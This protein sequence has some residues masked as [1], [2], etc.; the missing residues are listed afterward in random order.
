MNIKDFKRQHPDYADVPDQQLADALYRKHYAQTGM[1]RA[2]FYEKAQVEISE[3][4]SAPEQGSDLASVGRQV[5]PGVWRGLGDFKDMVAGAPLAA[6]DWVVND[7]VMP[8]F[9]GFQK[10]TP[11]NTVDVRVGFQSMMAPLERSAIGQAVNNA[12]QAMGRYLGSSPEPQDGAERAAARAGEIIGSTVPLVAVPYGVAATKPIQYASAPVS[13]RTAIG[14]VGENIVKG[15]MN[16]PGRTAAIEAGYGTLAG[17]GGGI[18][19]EAG[20]PTGEMI[21]SLALPVSAALATTFSPTFM[22]GRMLKTLAPSVSET[23]A[24]S[25]AREMVGQT[26]GEELPRYQGAVNRSREIEQAINQTAA[27]AGVAD[28]MNL[29]LAERTGSPAL[30]AAQRDLEGRMSGPAL[31]QAAKRRQGQDAA[32]DT[33]AQVNAPGSMMGPEDVARAAKA[34]SDAINDQL[35]RKLV[36][37]SIER[38]VLAQ[39]V[40]STDLVEAGA[41]IR[42]ALNDARKEVRGAFDQRAAA[43]GINT[44]DVTLDFRNFQQHVGDA[45]SPQTFDNPQYRPKVLDDIVRFG[46]D[47]GAQPVTFQEVKN[48]RE[49]IVDDL[50]VSQRSSNPTDRMRESSLS[51]LLRDFDGFITNTELR[52]AD[53]QLAERWT[54]FRRDYKN[55]YIDKFRQPDMRSFGARDTEGFRKMADEAVATDLFKPGNVSALRAYKDAVQAMDP[56]SPEF[57][58]GIEAIESVA[59]DSLRNAAVR[60]G[61]IDPQRYAA[62]VRQHQSM[63][64]E[65]PYLKGSVGE[66][67]AANQRLLSRQKTLQD[68]A[69]V[70]ERSVLEKKLQGIETG[71]RSP[72]ALIDEAIRNPGVASRLMSRLRNDDPAV[73]GLRAAVW[74]RIPFDDPAKTV[75]FLDANQKA[76]GAIFDPA[77]LGNARFIAEARA[78]ANRVPAPDGI[79]PEQVPF[80]ALEERLGMKLPQVGTRLYAVQSGRV[81]KVYPAIETAMNFVRGRTKRQLDEIWQQALYDPAVAKNLAETMRTGDPLSMGELAKQTFKFGIGIAP[82]RPNAWYGGAMVPLIEDEAPLND[83]QRVILGLPPAKRDVSALNENQRKIAGAAR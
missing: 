24:Q 35:H 45:Y 2:Q 75:Q 41:S 37:N 65:M 42:G 78:M 31:E 72:D 59:L 51:R 1:T 38:E 12:D 46:A 79:S 64:D 30:V 56:A 22:A 62:W 69:N 74:E 57:L 23:A 60:D 11:E 39:R 76:L 44:A 70:V 6:A 8:P 16:A 14:Q 18:G 33:F 61:V 48:L 83:N 47:E 20:G 54:N 55:G 81:G 7:V 28:R 26:L 80:R 9:R 36:E 50:L 5:A 17:I 43:E 52:G 34:R 3:P 13:A 68:R 15:T 66:V 73:N 77:H 49:R 4:E 32:I 63:L 25:K 29:S 53:P 58:R 71:A 82:D 10:E 21:G 40:P 19:N 67:D 27:N